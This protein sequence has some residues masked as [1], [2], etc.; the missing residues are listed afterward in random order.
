MRFLHIRNHVLCPFITDTNPLLQEYFFGLY[1]A[2]SYLYLCVCVWF[3]FVY[4][5]ACMVETVYT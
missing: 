4:Y 1:R 3:F 2:I 5:V